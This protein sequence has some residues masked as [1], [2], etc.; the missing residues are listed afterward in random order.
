MLLK[1]SKMAK[2]PAREWVWLECSETGDR[3]YR[4]QVRVGES[5]KLELIKY[6]PKLRKRTL[7]KVSRKK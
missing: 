1:V 5:K 6:C 2:G 3:N 4:T 7:H